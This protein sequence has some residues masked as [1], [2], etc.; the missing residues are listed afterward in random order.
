MLIDNGNETEWVLGPHRQPHHLA[1]DLAQAARIILADEAVSERAV[2]GDG[3]VTA[4]G[5]V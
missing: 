4:G 1:A 2:A 3:R 5:C